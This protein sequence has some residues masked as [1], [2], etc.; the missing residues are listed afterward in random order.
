MIDK[1]KK[2]FSQ[3]RSET[4]GKTPDGLC[5]NCWGSQEYDHIIREMFID[6]QV[7]VNNHK[8]H[9]SF[10]QDFVINKVKGITL[11]K[12]SNSY[13]CPTCHIAYD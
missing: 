12:G 2:F 9:H 4:T 3:K 13:E 10:I 1:L 7:D 11:V 5:P 8:A 6:K